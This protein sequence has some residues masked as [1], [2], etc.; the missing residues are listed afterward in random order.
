M[1]WQVQMRIVRSSPPLSALAI[2]RGDN[3]AKTLLGDLTSKM[4]EDELV[5]GK[6]ELETLKKPAEEQPA[7]EKPKEEKK[8]K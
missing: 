1:G 5:Q 2:E 7:A 3:E 8:D 6:K 4:K